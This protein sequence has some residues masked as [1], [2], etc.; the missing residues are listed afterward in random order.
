MGQQAPCF[1]TLCPHAP[2]MRLALHDIARL[3]VRP[4]PRPRPRSP[5]LPC[6][7]V[8]PELPAGIDRYRQA[9]TGSPII[10]ECCPNVARTFLSAHVAAGR[11]EYLPHTATLHHCR[12]GVAPPVL[13]RF[14]KNTPNTRPPSPPADPRQP[15]SKLTADV[16]DTHHHPACPPIKS[17]DICVDRCACEAGHLRLNQFP[18]WRPWHLGGSKHLPAFLPS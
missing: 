4:S 17:A 18:T 16:I 6:L 9:A 11:Q 15:P 2:S 8:L 5:V 3:V 12:D 10:A 14:C 7:P 13:A 1:G